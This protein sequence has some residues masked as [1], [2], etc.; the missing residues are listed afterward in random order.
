MAGNT[1]AQVL[2][3]RQMTQPVN[4]MVAFRKAESIGPPPPVSEAGVPRTSGMLKLLAVA[5]RGLPEFQELN[6]YV[7]VTDKVVGSSV[8]KP[9]M[10]DEN[11][12]KR[13]L[14]RFGGRGNR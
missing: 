4:P 1:L 5:K 14:E 12:Y 3:S 11:F 10:M 9:V 7:P 2:M 6:R 8:N 13:L